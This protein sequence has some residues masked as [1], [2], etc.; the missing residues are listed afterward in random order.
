VDFSKNELR[1]RADAQQI[2]RGAQADLLT[3]SVVQPLDLHK[4]LVSQLA[5]ELLVQGVSDMRK[6]YLVTQILVRPFG[7]R[8]TRFGGCFR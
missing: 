3:N 5:F 8:E 7:R 4:V 2:P 1:L 6:D